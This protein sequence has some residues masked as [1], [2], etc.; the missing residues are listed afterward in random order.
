ML[1]MILGAGLALTILTSAGCGSV[2]PV[3]ATGQGG[4]FVESHG[5]N[6]NGS[7]SAE[8]MKALKAAVETC[9]PLGKGPVMTDSHTVEPAFG[10]A[11]SAEISFRCE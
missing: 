11:P 1:K 10:R 8:K 9:Q 4:Y 5:I 2:S 7:G 3:L 6:G